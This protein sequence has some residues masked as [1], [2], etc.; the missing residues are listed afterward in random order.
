MIASRVPRVT[1]RSVVPPRT[2]DVLAVF[3][4]CDPELRCFAVLAAISGARRGEV[5]GLQWRD[6]N[7][8]RMVL[9][10]R[11]S[12]TEPKGGLQIKSTKTGRPRRVSID[13]VAH[14]AL[15]EQS[16]RHLE[17][18]YLGRPDDFVF[19]SPTCVHG[20]RPVRP[21]RITQA[22]AVACARAG[23]KIRL[24][25]LRH[26]HAS[27]LISDGYDIASV[28]ARLGHAKT[29]TTLNVYSHIMEDKGVLMA[30]AA[31]ARL[32]LD[33]GRTMQP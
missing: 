21:H 33:S 29:S 3:T 9:T 10:F 28:S 8:E 13:A 14:A 30:E 11:Q 19:A 4:E 27:I 17:R 25:D 1:G 16:T 23:V 20:D 24:H 6:V 2:E 15:T 18:G 32:A 12:I 22:W 7:W 5:C 31:S 26:W